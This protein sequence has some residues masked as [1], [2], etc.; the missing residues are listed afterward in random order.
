MT[1]TVG[2]GGEGMLSQQRPP[3]ADWPPDWPAVLISG[4]HVRLV[5]LRSEKSAIQFE[6]NAPDA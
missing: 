5:I 4:G 2:D 3:C 6:N 1:F